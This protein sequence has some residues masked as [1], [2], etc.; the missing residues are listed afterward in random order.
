MLGE[1]IRECLVQ[2]HDCALEQILD[3]AENRDE[4]TKRTNQS[5]IMAAKT[6]L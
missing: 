1:D 5:D 4:R 6:A 3:E 2:I